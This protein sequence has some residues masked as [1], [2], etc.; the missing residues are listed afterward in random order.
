[1][2][3]NT[4]LFGAFLNTREQLDRF[5]EDMTIYELMLEFKTYKSL[6][7][8]CGESRL[9]AESLLN[10][11]ILTDKLEERYPIEEYPEVW[12]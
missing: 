4:E 12:L 3:N 1:M 9:V 6:C 2:I 7:M 11:Q 8:Q 5:L 10:L